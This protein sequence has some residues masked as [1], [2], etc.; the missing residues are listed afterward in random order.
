MTDSPIECD[1]L[2][3]AGSQKWLIC[4]GQSKLSLEKTNR[5]REHWG[6][7]PLESVTGFIDRVVHE[8]QPAPRVRKSAPAKRAPKRREDCGCSS[9]R[10]KHGAGTELKELLRAAGVPP[11]QD[12]DE[13]AARMNEWGIEGCAARRDAPVC[14]SVRDG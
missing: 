5:Y 13:A 10:P 12:C 3:E 7:Y 8:A 1:K 11:C 2:F 4:T 6:L 14:R 9:P